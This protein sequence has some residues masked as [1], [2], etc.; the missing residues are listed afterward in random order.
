MLQL[1]AQKATHFIM[2]EF[3]VENFSSAAGNYI[4]AAVKG[5]ESYSLLQTL[6]QDDINILLENSRLEICGGVKNCISSLEET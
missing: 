5:T 6:L 4:F 3:N 1:K 2:S